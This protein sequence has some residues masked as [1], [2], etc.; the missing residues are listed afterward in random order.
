MEHE[1]II[2]KLEDAKARKDQ[3]LLSSDQVDTL[4]KFLKNSERCLAEAIALS[5]R[6]GEKLV[7]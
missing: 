7:S 5:L 6:G 4:L 2:Q 3:A 1:L